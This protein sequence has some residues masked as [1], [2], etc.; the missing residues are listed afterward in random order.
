LLQPLALVMTTPS[1]A[2]F[3][4][5]LTGWVFAR[6]HTVTGMILAA[7]AAGTKHPSAFHR[8]FA[9]AQWSLDELGLA[10]FGLIQPWR[11]PGVILVVLDDTLARKCGKKV[12]GVGM[13]CGGDMDVFVEPILPRPVW[14]VIG[15]GRIA[16]NLC[17][18]A[19]MLEFEVVLLAHGSIPKNL[20]AAVTVV[21]DDIEFTQRLVI[22][23]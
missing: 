22:L 15:R 19:D 17:L 12:F 8:F 21:Q 4:T 16:E 2:S 3:V 14:W 6:R 20:P 13:P 18:L 11:V 5:L 9:A 10:V 23:L 1:F 7:G